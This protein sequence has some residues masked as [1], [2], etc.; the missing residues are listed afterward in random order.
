[1]SAG[2]A[3]Q[4]PSLNTFFHALYALLALTFL[5]FPAWSADNQT[6][7]VGIVAD[8]QP[9][10]NIEGRIPSG[11][12]IDV[13]REVAHHAGL[14]LD[15]RAGTWPEIFGAFLHGDIDV[16]EGISYREERAKPFS[17][18]SPT[19]SARPT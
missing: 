9:Y 18:P 13:L 2:I 8:N 1:M 15:F 16:I 12:S 10:S 6:V 17:S 3:W 5:S 4:K 14:T 19:T 11:F 7:S